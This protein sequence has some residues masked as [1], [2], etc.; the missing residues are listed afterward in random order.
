MGRPQTKSVPDRERQL[1][2]SESRTWGL[3]HKVAI[4]LLTGLLIAAP[5][6]WSYGYREWQLNRARTELSRLEIAQADRRLTGLVER[7]PRHPEVLFWLGRAERRNGDLVEAMSHLNLARKAGADEEQVELQIRLMEAQ[8]GRVADAQSFVREFAYLNDDLISEEVYEALTQGFMFTSRYLDALQCLSYWID[9]RGK[10]VRPRLYR[11][12]VLE[13][14][15]NWQKALDEYETI[16]EFAPENEEARRAYA[17]VLLRFDDSRLAL[18]QYES[19]LERHPEDTELLLGRCKALENNGE[20]TLARKNYEQL[21]SRELD[22]ETRLETLIGLGKLALFSQRPQ[23]ARD[24]LEDAVRLGPYNYDAHFHLAAAYAQLKET[25]KAAEQK[26]RA[27]TLNAV[28]NRLREII[29]TLA[30]NPENADLRFEVGAL[31]EQLGKTR[32]AIAWWN[33][34]TV[35]AP[36]H[37]P[38]HRRLEQYYRQQGNQAE[39]E[40]HRHLAE[41]AESR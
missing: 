6:V 8:A 25:E 15:E 11:A 14:I 39:A 24:Y 26:Q 19:L 35:I 21:L 22:D 5:F 37:A 17:R 20:I 3:R 31:L 29:E 36:N 33:A 40:K 9:W 30:K 7:Y 2:E 12:E 38:T 28:Q 34:A 1:S 23:E 10:Q 13:R 27:E 4:V 41:R 18:E 16:L 32:E